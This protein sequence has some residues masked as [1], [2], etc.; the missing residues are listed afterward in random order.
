M[1]TAKMALNSSGQQMY[2]IDGIIVSGT[3]KIRH[4]GRWISVAKHPKSQII[5]YYEPPLIYCL[6]TSLKRVEI[7][8]EVYMDWDEMYDEEIETILRCDASDSRE[9]INSMELHSHFDGGFFGE[10]KITMN[11]GSV[12]YIK[13]VQVGDVLD[14]NII[15]FGVVTVNGSTLNHH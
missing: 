9:P 14:N 10:T 4:K 12:K 3:H 11:D 13:D 7:N 15:V 8:G 6:N 1:V 2:N 5:P